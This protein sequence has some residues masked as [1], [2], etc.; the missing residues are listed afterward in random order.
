MTSPCRRLPLA[1]LCLVATQAAA[2]TKPKPSSVIPARREF[3]VD[4]KAK[5]CADFYAHACNEAI[6]GF[7]LRDDRSS[8]AFAFN[9]SSERLLEAK[10]KWLKELAAAKTPPATER[11]REL[12]DVFVACNDEKA[13]KLEEPRLVKTALAEIDAL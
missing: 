12:R 4:T 11:A 7:K 6:A 2:A 10:K 8:H 13:G 5:P 9:D 3:P 1:A